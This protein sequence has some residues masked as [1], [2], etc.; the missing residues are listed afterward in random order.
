MFCP[1]GVPVFATTTIQ[2]KWYDDWHFYWYFCKQTSTI[3]FVYMQVR[4][5]LLYWH[6]DWN[7]LLWKW[8][9]I[10]IAS[11][12]IRNTLWE[13]ICSTLSGTWRKIILLQMVS[14]W[15]KTVETHHVLVECVCKEGR[16]GRVRSITSAELRL[17]SP[18][19]CVFVRCFA[20]AVQEVRLSSKWQH[21]W[22][23]IWTRNYLKSG[24]V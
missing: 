12:R 8:R 5:P 20:L 23:D 21:V 10:N 14:C 1:H 15:Q 6:S 24:S 9:P 2:S 11:R 4:S 16:R 17:I 22:P 18:L 19:D 13:L 3:F 7:C